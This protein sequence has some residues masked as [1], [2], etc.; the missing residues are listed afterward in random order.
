MMVGLFGK[1]V[2]GLILGILIA[3]F[4][5]A[6]RDRAIKKAVDEKK[7]LNWRFSMNENQELHYIGKPII[8]SIRKM[9]N[10]FNM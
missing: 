2:I 6:M 10:K 4:I 8:D 5:L 1:F 9:L 3:L 7:S